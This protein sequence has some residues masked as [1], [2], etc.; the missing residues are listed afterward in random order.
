MAAKGQAQGEGAS[1]LP[2]KMKGVM[3]VARGQAAILEEPTP[4]I[5]PGKIL[6]RTLL[7]GLTN[8]TERNVLMGGN[9]GG[10]WPSRCGYQNVGQVL[11]VAADVKGYAAGDVVFC[12]NFCQHAQ[13][14]A[15][16]VSKADDP[17][18]LCVKLPPGLDLVHAALMGMAGVALHDARRADVGLGD[19]VLVVGAGPI[20]QFTAQAARAAGANVRICDLDARRLAVAAGLGMAT[21]QIT[22]DASWNELRELGPFEAVFEDSGGPVLDKI[23]GAGWGKGLLVP[24][25]KVVV[26]AGRQEV[27]YNFNAG[28]GCELTLLQAGHFERGDLLELLRLILAG[29]IR[30][31]PIL[32]DV[33]A[34]SQAT[35]I[36]DRLRDNPT[37][38]MGTVFDWR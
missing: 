20:G 33:V 11:E 8:G 18:N 13:Y 29:A 19:K 14:F 5:A 12:A 27:T 1:A 17:W 32:Q 30:V 9:Y 23:I 16:D 22:G 31:G 36:Y 6:C 28:Q 35:P 24:R 21:T 34:C 4:Q 38:L 25:G 15:V 26:I 7:S 2:E 3:F 10:S 37:S